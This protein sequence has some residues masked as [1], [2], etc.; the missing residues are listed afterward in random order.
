MVTTARSSILVDDL[1]DVLSVGQRSTMHHSGGAPSSPSPRMSSTM[2]T[3]LVEHDR[4]PGMSNGK[5]TRGT[6]KYEATKGKKGKGKR[7]KSKGKSKGKGTPRLITPRPAQAQNGRPDLFPS[8]TLK[9][10]HAHQMVTCSQR[11][12]KV[13]AY[14]ETCFMGLH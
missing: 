6:E 3:K 13:Q 8:H 11:C 5:S 4:T 14:L 1:V 10:D 9:P 2:R 12:F 7:S